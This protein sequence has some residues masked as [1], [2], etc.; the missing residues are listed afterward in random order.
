MADNVR[1]SVLTPVYN[2]AAT[3]EAA[4]ATLSAQT[5]RDF[6]WIVVDDGSTDGTAEIADRIAAAWERE[7]GPRVRVVHQPNGGVS[8]ARNRAM[9]EAKGEWLVGLDADDAYLPD[10]LERVAR[11]VD[12]HPGIDA[13]E[14][15]YLV[16]GDEGTVV[17]G[18]GPAAELSGEAA[19][20]RLYVDPATRG[21]HWQ[22]WRFAYRR[23]IVLPRFRA[24]VI[25][26]DVDVL[27]AHLKTLG[28][29]LVADRPFYVYTPD[30][31]GAATRSFTPR[32]VRDIL[33]VTERNW[34]CE[35]LRPMLVWNIWGYYRA[36]ERFA[37]SERR[38]L[39]AAFRAH[40]EYLGLAAD[41]VG[42]RP[43]LDVARCV[44]IFLVVLQHILFLG[45]LSN[46][47]AGACHKLQA[48]F[49]EAASQ[50]CVDIF[51][52]LTG[53]LMAGTK[54]TFARLDDSARSRFGKFA[55]LWAQVFSTGLLVLGGCWA[56]A[57][58][59]GRGVVPAGADWLRAAFPIWF[60]EYWYFTGYFFVF[61]LAPVVAAAA[62]QPWARTLA[63]ALFVAI[64]ADTA[65]PG[66]LLGDFALPTCLM[67]KGGY[68]SVW[69]IL[70]AFW[71]MV[72][73]NEES[74]RKK[75]AWAPSS[76]RVPLA[77]C[78]VLMAVT[79]GQRFVM[80]AVP[81]VKAFFADEWTLHH[82]TS[83]T[84]VL[85]S[86]AFLLGCARLDFG[87]R[88]RKFLFLAAPCAF[89]VYLLHVQPFFFATYFKGRFAFLDSV[90]G[91]LFGLVSL[92]L[93]ALIFGI[94]VVLELV[95]RAAV[96]KFVT[97]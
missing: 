70:L 21:Q 89:G 63:L 12:A 10:A 83:P 33:G 18:T 24:G 31:E 60:D 20:R 77:V 14:F 22:P 34:T 78:A 92:V 56:F 17:H 88:I 93:S 85:A 97:S 42:R 5:F 72:L 44:A 53:Y 30:R 25:H 23:T 69:L 75:E 55:P 37:E 46:E 38:E 26:E 64:G 90:P 29:V 79:A 41:E 71:G 86:A 8:V 9:D 43:G 16:K 59:S 11:L 87:R 45:G 7:A 36:A 80:A 3:L 40:P 51:G 47:G 94:C 95:R 96:R 66:G 73:K 4:A 57:A 62:R 82:Y 19:F 35:E 91:C 52:L 54:L 67:L 6:E 48:R 68:S 32:R 1:F 74:R 81:S 49:L 39:L 65:W 76:C 50:C 58:L 84:V 61:L 28:R 27:P 15:P 13:I 2:G